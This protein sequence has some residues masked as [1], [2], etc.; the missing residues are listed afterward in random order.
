MNKLNKTKLTHESTYTNH[1]GFQLDR[2]DLQSALMLPD[3]A[4]PLFFEHLES[5]CNAHGGEKNYKTLL[6]I[7]RKYQ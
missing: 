2:Q 6:E 5:F 1:V 3:K 7:I 4:V